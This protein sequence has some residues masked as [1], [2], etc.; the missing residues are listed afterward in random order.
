MGKTFFEDIEESRTGR[1]GTQV[2]PFRV[3]LC[4]IDSESAAIAAQSE[5]AARIVDELTMPSSAEVKAFLDNPNKFLKTWPVES[6]RLYMRRMLE[7]VLELGTTVKTV[8]VRR[9]GAYFVVDDGRHNVAVVRVARQLL[10]GEIR[11]DC[12]KGV[13]EKVLAERGFIENVPTLPACPPAIDASTGKAMEPAE[14]AAISQEV[15]AMTDAEKYALCVRRFAAFKA[16]ERKP[17][18][19]S[20]AIDYAQTEAT[21][22]SW[23]KLASFPKAMQDLVFVGGPDGRLLP[24]T[25]ALS[26]KGLSPD[27]MLAKAQSMLAQGDTR[28]ETA[29]NTV[30]EMLN[31]DADK[32]DR[33]AARAAEAAVAPHDPLAQEM[34]ATGESPRSTFPQP[35]AD[36]ADRS[37]DQSENIDAEVEA[38]GAGEPEADPK[39]KLVRARWTGR[40]VD[41]FTKDVDEKVRES[42]EWEVFA[43]YAK[44][45]TQSPDKLTPRDFAK[46]GALGKELKRH[47][48]STRK[49]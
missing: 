41:R 9:V 6:V 22:R 4:G 42:E 34:R 39:Q 35:A 31:R 1:R 7:K 33:T 37:G 28:A 25:T 11:V 16:A 5:E 49:K 44:L 43:V 23:E 40:D 10:A 46:L 14:V 45:F 26:L 29:R 18:Y 19:A 15:R 3:F 32:A 17:N 48:K 36:A 8:T 38:D 30:R 2:D 21:I 47:I 27:V 12:V 24:I 20:L 13:V